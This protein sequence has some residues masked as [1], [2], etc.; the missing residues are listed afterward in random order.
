M[1]KRV[2]LLSF[3]LLVLVSLTVAAVEETDTAKIEIAFEGDDLK[4]L[5]TYKQDVSGKN[6]SWQWFGKGGLIEG[7]TGKTLPRELFKRGDG[8]VCKYRDTANSIDL[9][10]TVIVPNKPPV[11][12]VPER[13][14]AL[15]GKILNKDPK[16]TDI[17]DDEVTLTFS[18]PFDD[19]GRWADTMSYAPGEFEVT[20]TADDGH[21]GVVSDTVI[22]VLTGESEEERKELREKRLEKEERRLEYQSI[23]SS[24][25]TKKFSLIKKNETL[26]IENSNMNVPVGLLEILINKDILKLSLEIRSWSSD[27]KPRDWPGA[28]DNVYAYVEKTLYDFSNDDIE[29]VR[30]NFHVSKSWLNNFDAGTLMLYKL[31]D[32]SWEKIV[33]SRLAESDDFA[34]YEAEL[35]GLYDLAITAKLKT[36]PVKIPEPAEP[37]ATK[38]VEINM[39]N[40][41]PISK[42]EVVENDKGDKFSTG[43]AVASFEDEEIETEGKAWLW[44]VAIVVVAVIAAFVFTFRKPK[45]KEEYVSQEE[46][47]KVMQQQDRQTQADKMENAQEE[48]QRKEDVDKELGLG[49]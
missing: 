47:E 45:N 13:I 34:I 15:R 4:C 37:S 21:G 35:N 33:P 36:E 32:N 16:I 12:E 26:R 43:A 20:V 2:L 25:I 42:V 41:D 46:I 5:I 6:P 22:V 3:I 38:E 17:D 27:E 18:Q 14:E 29:N 7:Q 39:Q 19:E 31:A 8:V 24:T 48:Q 28:P 1:I 44:I 49:K 23:K 9:Q 40:E 10:K 11:L 30:L